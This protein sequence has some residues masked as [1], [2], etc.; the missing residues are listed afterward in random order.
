MF[1]LSYPGWLYSPSTC[2]EYTNICMYMY[3]K[4]RGGSMRAAECPKAAILTKALG[5]AVSVVAKA[6]SVG[7]VKMFP[8]YT[9]QLYKLF[10]FFCY[11]VT[12][13]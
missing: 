9:T 10:S 6:C 7:C 4:H 12:I 3:K 13:L 5:A 1:I 2:A 11:L 8:I